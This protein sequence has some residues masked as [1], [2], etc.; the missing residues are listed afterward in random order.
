[1]KVLRHIITILIGL[2]FLYYVRN[3][4]TLESE[5]FYN[6]INK[7][8]FYV[9]LFSLFLYFFSHTLRTFR[10]YILADDAS[11]SFT[12]LLALQI[13]ANAVNLLFP[14]KLGEAYRVLSFSKILGGSLKSI[15][16][17]AIERSFDIFTLFFYLSIG[18][19]ISDQVTL[20][21]I[22]YIY[23]PVLVLVVSMLTIIVIGE[24]TITMIQKRVLLKYDNNQS[25]KLLKFS[26]NALQKISY[27][28]KLIGSKIKQITVF[29]LLVWGFEV[30]CL[31][32][33]YSLIGFEIDIL[34]LLGVYIAFSSI[35]P[36][37]P[38]GLGG[39][40]LSFYYINET[41][42]L[43][44]DFISIS[45]VYGILIFGSGVAA[46]FIFFGISIFNKIIYGR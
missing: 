11:I 18:V 40:Q 42:Q 9:I 19:L 5:D 22:Y 13:K 38:I 15:I 23:V 8:D 25:I 36:N 24:D 27:L 31:V 45:Y 30:S 2:A 21:D 37:G 4:L 12:K 32:L 29:S 33:F 1:L 17:L 28:K 6:T 39:L 3:L 16:T 46:G 14:F 35:L 7:I 44:L 10:L 34:L 20:S 43:G 41:F 26:T